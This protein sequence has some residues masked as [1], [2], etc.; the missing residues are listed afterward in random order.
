MNKDF[1]AA[2]T[3]QLSYL[4]FTTGDAIG[5]DYAHDELPGAAQYA[6]DVVI[7]AHSTDDVAAVLKLCGDYG[8]P[9]TVRGAGT[10]KAGGS[11]PING[12]V[13]LSVKEMNG[14]L[15]FDEEA[16]TLTVQPGVLLQDVKAEAAKHGLVYPPDPGEQ[17]ATIGG[18]A[19]TDAGGPSAV[20][21]GSTRDYIA[22]AVIVLA[23]GTVARLSDKPE[24]AS[25]IG[26]EGTLAVITEL[27]LRLV[28]KPACDVILL[29]PFVDTE[30]CISAAAKIKAAGFSPAVLEYL[31]TD[32]V[33]FSGKVTGSPV[34]PVEMDGERVGAT[35]MLVLEGESDDALDEQM[36]A[37]A[38]L[39]EELECLD[40]LVVDTPTLKRDVWAAHDAFHTSMETA[41]SSGEL[42]VDVPT[43][44]IAALVD[45]AKSLGA[46][47]G[48][49]V[50][51]YA[52][53]G[54]G[55]LH[56]HAVSDAAKADF[57]PAM[58]VLAE[59]V[60]KKC[61]ALGGDIVGEYGVG[62]SKREALKE[63]SDAAEYAKLTAVKAAFDPKNILNPGK[64]VIL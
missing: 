38:E 23:D 19:S 39:A 31:D 25:V 24:Y 48:L 9:V 28:E 29:L 62:Y 26:S 61:A 44:Q 37:I 5:A 35:L 6:P 40:I 63:L 22:D 11:V 2:L 53:A 51:C 14:I 3:S 56:I 15:S 7:S 32:I 1:I 52:H 21:Y 36:E 64:V 33:E 45:F 49:N 27:T 4:P 60:Y 34:F 10:G 20:K 16:Q 18:N 12:G 54:S 30:S 58:A 42:N 50:M 43:E 46:E 41:K 55:G 13:V 57:A 8:V 59:A 47:K 17:T